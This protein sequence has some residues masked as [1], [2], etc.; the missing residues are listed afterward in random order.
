MPR[1]EVMDEFGC[2]TRSSSPLSRDL[3]GETAK[4][5]QGCATRTMGQQVASQGGSRR[6]SVVRVA[7]RSPP[8]CGGAL[9]EQGGY[10]AGVGGAVSPHGR[11]E[12]RV[13][14]AEVVREL[15]APSGERGRR[16]GPALKIGSNSDF[17]DYSSVD[18]DLE[19]ELLAA[20]IGMPIEWLL[21]ALLVLVDY[22]DARVGS[23]ELP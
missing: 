21:D 14:C 18:G 11:G 22:L 8:A 2:S 19:R 1:R 6:S 20:V 16:L 9:A 10:A 5:R 4:G 17:A 12:Y 7:L 3:E 23:P 15:G 13:L